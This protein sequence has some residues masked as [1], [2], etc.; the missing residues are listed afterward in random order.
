MSC[1]NSI[2]TDTVNLNGFNKIDKNLT[3][4]ILIIGGGICGIL[5]AYFLEQLGINYT[6]VEG[7]KICSGITKNTIAKITSQHN[8]I[9]DKLIKHF[10]LEKAKMYFLANENALLKYKEICKNIDC[11]FDI[12]SS[13]VYTTNNK[14]KILDE[15]KAVHNL[16]GKAE[17]LD[18]L[19]L[20]FQT[21]GA[22]EFFNQ[23]KFN[24][25]KFI[26]HI[27]NGL[28]IYENSYVSEI[29]KNFAICNGYKIKTDKIIVATHFPFLN[30]HG[31]Y[32]LKLY[33]Y[34]SY[35][36]A[37]KNTLSIKGMYIDESDRGVSFR[38]Y[39]DL[40]LLG[41]G[42]SKTGKKS[43]NF[44]FL[45]EFKDKYFENAKEIYAFATQDCMS[46]DGV[47]YIGSYSKNTKNLYVATGFNKWGMTSSMVA[48]MILSD[49]II[50]RKNEFQEVFSPQRNILTP[51]LFVNGVNAVKNLLTPTTIRCPHLGCALKFNK[52]ENSWDCPCHG[53][54]FDKNGHLIDNPS[55][56][57]ANV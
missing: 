55:M 6:L 56:K 54:R 48:A 5:C 35:V 30:K 49:M 25:L 21:Q 7:Q 27:S 52:V 11:D 16:G 42:G 14:Q 20:P 26:K 44:N 3:T 24:P 19:N 1:N 31:S 50:G 57:D 9:Y 37:I 33:Q 41:G 12:S 28:N 22:I 8:L 51:Q 32:F 36:I 53:S 17:F 18:H 34:R 13:F 23:A 40:L 46:L 2:W 29:G 38:D 45:R 10:G 39:S 15:V 43:G 47:P 4:D